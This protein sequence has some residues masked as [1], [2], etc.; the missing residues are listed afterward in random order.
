MSAQIVV[1]GSLNMDMVVSL[2]HRPQ[3]GETVLGKDFFMNPG[4]KGANAAV[5]ARKLGGSVAMIGKV[6]QDIFG[7]QLIAGLESLGIDASGVERS[8]EHATGIAFITL[9]ASGD[10]SIV[11]APGSNYALTPE[12]VRKFEEKISQAKLLMVQLEVPLE[13]VKE[14][15]RLAKKHGVQVLL[16][17]A[18]AQPLP[19]DLLGM[20]DYILPNEKEIEQLTGIP[21]SDPA[22]AKKAAEALRARGVATV[23]AKMGARGVVIVDRNGDTYVPAF[24]VKTVDTTAAGDTFAGAVAAALTRGEDILSAARFA[25]AAGALTVTRKGAQSAM[26][27]LEET[28][29]FMEEA[30]KV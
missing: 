1:V 27:T 4:G 15:V 21:V 16:D 7:D 28:L 25:S 6:G 22:T 30:E 2:E 13:T 17:P 24:K 26:P 20:V 5:S 10:N 14:A 8:A 3:Q 12:D 23:F 11:V 29:R 18:P 19:D 9:D